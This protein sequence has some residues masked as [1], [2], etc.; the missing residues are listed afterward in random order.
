[1][2]SKCKLYMP[3][4]NR[5]LYKYFEF[6][7][8]LFWMHAQSNRTAPITPGLLWPTAAVFAQAGTQLATAMYPADCSNINE[9]L[10]PYHKNGS[11]THKQAVL[12]VVIN[13]GLSG[14]RHQGDYDKLEYRW[15]VDKSSIAWWNLYGVG[16]LKCLTSNKSARYY[17]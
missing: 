13:I 9:R 15:P 4:M 2:K 12:S 7:I 11:V 14:S 1:M 8:T 3:L 17:L 10:F 16:R 6:S 5:V